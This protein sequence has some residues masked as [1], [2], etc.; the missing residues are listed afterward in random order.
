MPTEIDYRR[1]E[2]PD[3]APPDEYSYAERRAA[4][5]ERIEREGQPWTLNKSALGREY[6]VSHTTISNDFEALA[7][8]VAETVGDDHRLVTNSIL[9]KCIRE[10]LDEG[11]WSEAAR[12][13]LKHEDWLMD[14][15]AVERV[16]EKREIDAMVN[17]DDYQSD[18]YVIVEEEDGELVNVPNRSELIESG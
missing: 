11:E 10:L 3:D 17:S 6:G 15:G 12:I 2:I 1:I 9:Q 7:D 4:L 5:L 14:I 18:S 16:P 13:A 8:H